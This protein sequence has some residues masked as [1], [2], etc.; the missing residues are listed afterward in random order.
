MGEFAIVEPF[1]D[2]APDRDRQRNEQ[3]REWRRQRAI[4]NLAALQD[5]VRSLAVREGLHVDAFVV[6]LETFQ[7]TITLK[8]G[9][10]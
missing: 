6:D 4:A 9:A 3:R 5:D 1:E 7:I 2:R 8:R 10:S